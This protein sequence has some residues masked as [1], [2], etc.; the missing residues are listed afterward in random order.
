[1]IICIGLVF[2]HLLGEGYL[3]RMVHSMLEVATNDGG[4]FIINEEGTKAI[5]CKDFHKK[6][7][8]L[9]KHSNVVTHPKPL[10]DGSGLFERFIKADKS[11][12]DV[13]DLSWKERLSVSMAPSESKC[14]RSLGSFIE[15]IKEN[16]TK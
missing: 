5:D 16:K 2:F 15:A 14:A 12:L 11:I 4:T 1:V 9:I 6:F 8:E 7:P 10:N 3:L 13:S